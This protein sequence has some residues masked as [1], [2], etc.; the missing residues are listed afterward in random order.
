MLGWLTAVALVFCIED[1][2]EAS[3]SEVLAYDARARFYDHAD[4]VTPSDNLPGVLIRNL[5]R[6]HYRQLARSRTSSKPLLIW[7]G[8]LKDESIPAE[9]LSNFGRKFSARVSGKLLVD[10]G[11]GI[12]DN[13][14]SVALMARAF[15]ARAYVGVDHLNVPQ[16]FRAEHI[17][18]TN[19]RL[20]TEYLRSDMLEFLN[21]FVRPPE[22]VVFHMAGIEPLKTNIGF[23]KYFQPEGADKEYLDA[24]VRR[25]SEIMR[26]GDALIIGPVTHGIRPK[27]FGML[28]VESAD[29][30]LGPY[31]IWQNSFE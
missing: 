16:N 4:Q 8:F 6:L 18:G 27:V 9:M 20:S 26:P 22:G 30:D 14:L 11:S 12:P 28:L 7:E 3:H 13:S 5:P 23:R 1:L 24:V 25:I 29:T 10:L 17:P 15:S 19:L 31:V 2:R 21:T